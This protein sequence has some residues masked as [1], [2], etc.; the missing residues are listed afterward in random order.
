MSKGGGRAAV[1]WLALGY[2]GSYIPYS[3]LVRVTTS[4][5]YFGPALSATAL[6]PGAAIATAVTMTATIWLLGWWKYAGTRNVFGVTVPV[7]R[8]STLIAGLSFAVIIWTTTIAYSF[9]GISIVLALL[10]MRGGVLALA[11]IIDRISR[12]RVH[13]DAWTALALSFLALG[14]AFYEVGSYHF[15]LVAALNLAAYLCAYTFRLRQMASEA[16]SEDPA[17]NRRFFVEE[18]MVAMA[19]LVAVPALLAVLG[20]GAFALELRRG[21]GAA[22]SGPLA[23]PALLVGVCYGMLALFGT[24]IYLECSENTFCM[25][26]NRGSSLLSGVVAS[27]VLTLLVGA[28]LVSGRQLLAT[29]IVFAAMALLAASRRWTDAPTPAGQVVVQRIVLFVC[30]G[31]TS[32]SPMAQAICNSAIARR[33]QIPLETMVGAPIRAM[34]AGLTAEPGSPLS[35]HAERALSMMG[36]SRFRHTAIP[37]TAEMIASADAVYCMTES[38]RL[39]AIQL[40]PDARAKIHRLELDGDIPDPSGAPLDVFVEVANRIEGAVHGRLASLMPAPA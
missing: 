7:P 15:T 30:G 2:F 5:D 3:A 36:I 32:R 34:S 21:F 9:P 18:N 6:L 23:A 28:P 29:V 37:L 35:G 4:G 33:L 19:A 31:N 26:V 10:L 16:K 25:V 24:L 11:P 38:Q 12:R 39:A 40:C 20:T 1:W 17:V 22:L 27:Y 8:R 14:I 13:W